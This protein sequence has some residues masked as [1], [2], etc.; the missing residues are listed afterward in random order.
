MP[1]N[2]LSVSRS[3]SR[4]AGLRPARSAATASAILLARTDAFPDSSASAMA[5]SARFFTSVPTFIKESDA[6]FAAAACSIT[7][8]FPYLPWMP[9]LYY[10]GVPAHKGFCRIMGW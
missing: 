2:R 6:R 9:P 1:E 3:R 4:N 5:S 7:V 8:I 10:S